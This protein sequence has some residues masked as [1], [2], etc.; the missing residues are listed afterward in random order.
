M[1]DGAASDLPTGLS[2]GDLVEAKRSIPGSFLVQTAAMV[3]LLTAWAIGVVQLQDTLEPMMSR[4]GLNAQQQDL[5]VIGIPATLTVVWVIERAIR[6]QRRRRLE[7][8]EFALPEPGYFRI[9]PFG[10][11]DHGT[12]YKTRQDHSEADT[13]NWILGST[14]RLLYLTGRSGCGKSSLLGAHLVPELEERGWLV[15]S[16]RA[17]TDPLAAAAAAASKL[18][19]LGQ[20]APEAE[21]PARRLSAAGE[22]AKGDG[23]RLLIV[24]DQFEEFLILNDEDPDA[25]A[26]FKE[27]ISSL[28][29]ADTAGLT[30]LLVFRSDY[31]DLVEVCG[32]PLMRQGENWRELGPFMRKEA[33]DFL[34][35]GLGTIGTPLMERLLGGLDELEETPGRYRPVTLNMAGMV[36]ASGTGRLDTPP[37]QLIHR[38]VDDAIKDPETL[39]LAPGILQTMVTDAGTK[40][41]VSLAHLVAEKKERPE[42]IR[43]VLRRL[44]VSRLVR[45]LDPDQNSWE[46]SH[47]FV[48]RLIG[49]RLGRLRPSPLRFLRGWVVPG[50]QA[51]AVAGLMASA[52]VWHQGER[53]RL[54]ATLS[55]NGIVVREIGGLRVAEPTNP[56][57]F[58]NASLDSLG[59]DLDRW[60]EIETKP[61]GL[62]F[63]GTTIKDLGPLAGFVRLQSLHLYHADVDDLE[64]LRNLKGLKFLRVGRTGVTD[65]DPL[66][67]LKALQLL[68][69]GNNHDLKD[70]APLKGLTALQNLN[71]SW[72]N[73]T[74][75]EPLKDLSA[76]D[77]LNLTDTKG[78]ENLTQLKGLLRLEK[79][80]LSRTAVANLK[81]L[82]KL[83]ALVVLSLSETRVTDLS[84]LK[85]LTS[86]E[87]LDLSGNKG[88]KDLD[89]LRGLRSLEKLILNGT[90]VDDI[91]PVEHLKA[92]RILETKATPYSKRTTKD[93]E[94]VTPAPSGVSTRR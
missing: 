38:Y 7:A 21:D 42:T 28:L 20:P 33:V 2:E 52:W 87:F 54:I 83:K 6:W 59:P 44:A 13:L 5:L 15:C 89:P 29:G 57:A 10:P 69:L 49:Q 85:G 22:R 12:R 67:E 36:F 24:I 65:L 34:S 37:E 75:L 53:D 58:S 73:V 71:L 16:V 55:D 68:D 8:T 27:Q 77:T 47:D 62:N 30:V 39:D 56:S 40:R 70:L 25:L 43:G 84:P 74:D 72:T 93:P 14:E 26:R 86:L 50:L 63:S 78:I 92:L 66:K 1:G 80:F 64:P 9:E 79:L 94:A 90:S 32:L 18:G 35:G 48:A 31:S 19:V 61:T 17:G 82:K 60:V 91:G 3:V 41:P 51:L 45:S 4:F 88:I 23:K 76:L 11:G 46:I 81:P